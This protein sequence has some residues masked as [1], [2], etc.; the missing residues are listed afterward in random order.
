M[1]DIRNIWRRYGF[2]KNPYHTEHLDPSKE[3]ADLYVHREEGESQLGNFLVSEESGA[4]VVEGMIGVGKTTFVNQTQYQIGRETNLPDILPSA[5]LVEVLESTTPRGMLLNILTATLKALRQRSEGVEETSDFQEL[6]SYTRK[7]VVE[8]WTGGGSIMGV[9]PN[10]GKTSAPRDP[11]Q[12]TLQ[13]LQELLERTATLTTGRGFE[14]I[15]VLI[16]NLDNVEQEH[17]FDLLHDLRDSILARAPFVF[18][19]AGPRGLRQTLQR[20]RTHRRVSE[21]IRR[22]PVSLDPLTL[23]QVH[24]VIDKRVEHYGV[25]NRAE[26]PVPARAIDILYEA[27]EGE[28]RYVLNRAES[29]ARKV[30]DALPS[31]DKLNRELAMAALEDIVREEIETIDLTDRKREVLADIARH[32]TVQPKDYESFGFNSPQGFSNYLTGF[33]EMKLLEREKRGRETLY[34]PRGDVKLH[35]RGIPDD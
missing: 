24:R 23:E 26:A 32:E 15:V 20:N 27:S 29:I 13:T 8:S 12:V 30:T 9:G 17:F 10:L 25:D 35:Y 34:T 14:R 7:A 1:I 16:N 3:D 18:V 6:E 31:G 21:R 22:D 19:F 11:P 2:R 4:I 33:F 28:I 5:A